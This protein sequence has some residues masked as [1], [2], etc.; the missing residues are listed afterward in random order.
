MP[1]TPQ[2]Q[3]EFFYDFTSPTAYLAWA[4]LP[5]IVERT[6]AKLVYR[7]MFLGGVM[8]TTGNRPPGM[9]A[10]KGKWMMA[11]LDRWA[12]RFNTPF[13]RNPHF[14]MMTLMVQRAA[15]EWVARPDFDKYLAAIFNAAWRDQKN[16]ADKETLAAIVS[17]AGFSASDFFAAAENPANKEK[18]KATTDEAV[19]RGVFG[20]PTFFVGDEMHFGQDRLDF[21]EEALAR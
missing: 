7:P 11:D 6:G 5:S 18:L 20:A 14:P 15:Q 1:Q 2:K 12:K 17:E 16:I 19:A 10:A 8:Q 4:R 13:K 9:V 3:V 21:V